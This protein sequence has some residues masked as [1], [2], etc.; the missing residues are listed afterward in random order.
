MS[1]TAP[2]RSSDLSRQLAR[3]SFLSTQVPR[4][5]DTLRLDPF[6]AMPF[7]FSE[8]IYTIVES[9]YSFMISI[10]ESTH[11]FDITTTLHE[12]TRGWLASAHSDE[13]VC[14]SSIAYCAWF[15]SERMMQ[16]PELIQLSLKNEARTLTLLRRRIETGE[17]VK[18]GTLFAAALHFYVVSSTTQNQSQ[19]SRIAQGIAAMVAAYRGKSAIVRNVSPST[20]RALIHVDVFHSLMSTQKPFLEDLELPVRPASYETIFTAPAIDKEVMNCLGPELVDVLEDLHFALFFLTPSQQSRKLSSDES[21]YLY[22]LLQRISHGLCNQQSRLVTG[23]S[24]L[25]IAVYGMILVQ[26]EVMIDIVQHSIVLITILQRL[27]NTISTYQRP[28][29]GVE[30][31][32]ALWASTVALVGTDFE[33]ERL[34][35]IEFIKSTLI[36]IYG[37]SWPENWVTEL[38]RELQRVLWHHRIEVS[39]MATCAR[40]YKICN[41]IN[42]RI[43]QQVSLLDIL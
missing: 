12:L 19:L 23:P 26:K 38:R 3:P 30:L 43:I 39:F 41:R 31:T 6:H 8:N 37:P 42:D 9:L 34:W 7:R 22:V 16:Q 14:T 28:L 4:D 13:A 21:R 40:V 10:T 25:K 1:V 35:A 11:P 29:Q 20:R 15:H 17:A 24:L 5:M 2:R 32:V 18:E 27:G 36:N 33:S